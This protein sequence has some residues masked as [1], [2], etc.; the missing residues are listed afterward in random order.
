M[1]KYIKLLYLFFLISFLTIISTFAII[2]NKSKI[3]FDIN[4]IYS[5]PKLFL[6]D[7][8]VN[9]LLT[10]NLR[11]EYFKIKDSLD[12]NMLEIKM[13]NHPV[14]DN[15][16]IYWK[17]SNVLE[18]E[19]NERQP[20]FIVNDDIQLFVDSTGVS[21]PIS[22]TIDDNL[23]LVF[24]GHS[25][26]ELKVI[27]DFVLKLK[28]DPFINKE[29][30]KIYFKNNEFTIF[31]KSFDFKILF[32]NSFRFNEKIQKLKVFCA[33]QNSNDSLNNYPSINLKYLNQVVASK[34]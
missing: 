5:N 28:R 21:F 4:I 10:Q 17:Y 34:S 13:E 31:L 22:K 15:T 8:I 9:K 32:G 1:R 7:S 12:L 30:D 29:L 26:D 20:L 2:R 19:I 25:N 16:E 6:N 33:F 11:R 3:I 23:P 24:S 18:L 27:T 14:I